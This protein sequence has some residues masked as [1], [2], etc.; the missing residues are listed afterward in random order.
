M[1]LKDEL[2]GKV[3]NPSPDDPSHA[4]GTYLSAC[5][6]S[7]TILT[8]THPIFVTGRIDTVNPWD[9]E[10]PFIVRIGEWSDEST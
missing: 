6:D 8:R 2:L 5:T 7:Q 1:K 4:D 3:V 9:L 10:I